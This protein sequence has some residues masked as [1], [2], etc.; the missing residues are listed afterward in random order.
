ML[1]TR[2]ALGYPPQDYNFLP[3]WLKPK[4]KDTLSGLVKLLQQANKRV[5]QLKDNVQYWKRKCE[6]LNQEYLAFKFKDLC[7]RCHTIRDTTPSGDTLCGWDKDTTTS[8][9]LKLEKNSITGKTEE[10]LLQQ[11]FENDRGSKAGAHKRVWPIGSVLQR[12]THR[13]CLVEQSGILRCRKSHV[14]PR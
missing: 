10:S 6:N 9:T 8:L 13:Q 1:N 12:R 5:E 7:E 4:P 2:D 11:Y 14:T 3:E